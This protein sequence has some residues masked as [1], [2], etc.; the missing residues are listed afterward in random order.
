VIQIKHR[1]TDQVLCEFDV[2]TLKEAVVKAVSDGADLRGADLR[3]A[4]LRGAD[5]RGADLRGADLC[6]ANL[7]GADLG[8]ADLYGANLYGADLGGAELE[9]EKLA[10]APIQIDG[11]VWL[12]T[13]SE[14]YMRIGCQRHT[15]DEW[16]GFDEETISDMS[17]DALEFWKHHKSWLLAACKSHRKASLQYRK[18]HPELEEKEAA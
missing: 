3:G 10:I 6:G 5:L 2:G 16:K 4:D 1:Y 14:S 13:I 15:H 8:D 18:D 11:L 7:Y 9:G 17:G 12:V